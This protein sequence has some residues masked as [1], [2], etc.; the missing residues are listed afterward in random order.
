MKIIHPEGWPRPKG[1]SN[2]ILT[3]GRMIFIAGQVG[4]NQNEK[5]ESLDFVDQTRQAL[6]NILTI[7][8]Q[9]G[10]G[11][12]HIVRMTWFV[13]DANEYNDRLKEVGQVYRDVIGS[14]YPAMSMLQVAGF[15]ENGAC[16]E[17]ETTAVIP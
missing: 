10:A 7:L 1:Y 6:S 9:A 5:F 3:E 15:V 14:H 2:A 12:E 16:V 13:A 17:I 8:R 11:A 4:W